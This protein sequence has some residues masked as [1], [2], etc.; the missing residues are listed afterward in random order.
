MLSFRKCQEAV[1]RETTKA[2]SIEFILYRI[3]Q[4]EQ[5][6]CTVLFTRHQSTKVCREILIF[7]TF[8]LWRPFTQHVSHIFSYSNF[9]SGYLDNQSEYRKSPTH[10]RWLM[11]CASDCAAILLVLWNLIPDKFNRR[12]LGRFT[13]Y[14]LL[15]LPKRKHCWNCIF[16]VKYIY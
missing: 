9:R 13:P 8:F 1:R 16:F 15:T 5:N 2:S 10:F 6:G 11:P 4:Y 3:P 7:N 12:S 14:C